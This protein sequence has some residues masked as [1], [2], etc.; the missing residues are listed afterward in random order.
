MEGWDDR[1]SPEIPKVVPNELFF[2]FLRLL[3]FFFFHVS[4]PFRAISRRGSPGGR[5]RLH[6][7]ELLSSSF[8]GRRKRLLT[9]TDYSEEESS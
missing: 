4:R 5:G 9:V 7:T 1:R 8:I 2:S 6:N 3:L